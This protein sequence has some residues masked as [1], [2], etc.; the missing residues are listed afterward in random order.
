MFAKVAIEEILSE[1]EIK[2]GTIVIIES[3]TTHPNAN[4]V[5]IF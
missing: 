1:I 2:L 5:P 3:D 4:L